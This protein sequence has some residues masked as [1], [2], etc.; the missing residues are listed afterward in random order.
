MDARLLDDLVAAAQDLNPGDNLSPRV[1]RAIARHAAARPV[2][3]S[4][5]TG[6]GGSTLLL[7]QISGHHTAFAIEGDNR[8]VTRVK[9]SVF[10]REGTTGIVE[11]PTQATLPGYRFDGPLDA[12]LIDGPHAFPFP[13]LEYYYLYPHIAEN[14]LLV[15]DDIH[16]RT[17]HE[18][19]RF[20]RRDEMFDVLEVVGRTAFYRRTSAPVFD[21][22]G[23]G[24]WRQ[25][26]NRKRLARYVWRESL[27]QALPHRLRRWLR[28]KRPGYP[29]SIDDPQ[30]N[31]V[32][33]PSAVVSGKA[34]LPTG[35]RLWLFARRAD[36]AGWWPQ[37]GAPVAFTG[38]QWR[39]DCKFGEP[40]DTG[41]AFEIAAVAV[42]EPGHARVLRW[43]AEAERSGIWGPMALPAPPAAIVTVKRG[44]CG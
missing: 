39:H 4:A 20:L 11:G 21:P 43:L 28:R 37:G 40:M 14:G 10:F 31:S 29:A 27:A 32:V 36:A 35:C 26:Y 18:L 15:L 44:L 17:I 34:V 25:A 6:A 23:D 22:L 30:A 41:F 8:I 12:V 5:E 38:C 19:H 7:S 16:I 9:A 24:W 33:G 13:Q 42:D 3:R 1:L 2:L